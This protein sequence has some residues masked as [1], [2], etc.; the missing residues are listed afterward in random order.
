[1]DRVER[2]ESLWK[3]HLERWPEPDE[4]FR[5]GGQVLAR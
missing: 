2:F 4:E 1:M 3:A 5:R